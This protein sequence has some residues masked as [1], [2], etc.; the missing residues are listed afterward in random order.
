MIINHKR[1]LRIYRALALD[2]SRRLNKRVPARVKQPLVVPVAANI[3]WS[4]DS[5]SDVLTDGRQFRTLNVLDDY[6][7]QLLGVEIDF[8]LP[9]TRV[10]QMLMR[11]VKCHGRPA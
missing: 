2:L 6:N 3:C 5:T 9:A 10:V 7:R 4:L 11:L 8:S 1:T